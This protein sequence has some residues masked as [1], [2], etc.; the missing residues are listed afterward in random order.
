MIPLRPWAANVSVI[1]I[2]C[3]SNSSFLVSSVIARLYCGMFRMCSPM[4]ITGSARGHTIENREYNG[5]QDM[6]YVSC[7]LGACEVRGN[8]N[9][10]WPLTATCSKRLSSTSWTFRSGHSVTRILDLWKES[11]LVHL[12]RIDSSR[13]LSWRWNSIIDVTLCQSRRVFSTSKLSN[14]RYKLF[15]MNINI[16]FMKSIEIVNIYVLYKYLYL[17]II[18]S[19]F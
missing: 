16:I 9:S 6:C 17:S 11:S 8:A 1:R 3:L 4:I 15:S 12:K 10:S 14:D 18:S 5:W 7:Y 19:R 13:I 2:I